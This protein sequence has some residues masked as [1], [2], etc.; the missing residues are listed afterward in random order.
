M[1][2]VRF[3]IA[4]SAAARP[5]SDPVAAARHA[6]RL[7]FDLIPVSDRLHGSFPTYETWTLLTWLA[8][9]TE[10]VRVAPLVLGLPYRS[11]VVVAKMAESLDRLSGGRA[12]LG[13][14]GGGGGGGVRGFGP[15]VP[16]PAHRIPIWLGTYGRRSLALTG[17]VAD[18]WNPSFAYAPPEMAG[19]MLHNVRR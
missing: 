8:A 19:E 12:I 16:K 11:P 18:G 10:R 9:S 2:Q 13:L 3:G 14:G 15:A 17:R 7:G 4:V 5:D 1:G 6:E